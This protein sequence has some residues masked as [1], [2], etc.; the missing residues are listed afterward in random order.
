MNNQ[1]LASATFA[2]NKWHIS[3]YFLTA[4][5]NIKNKLLIQNIFFV[6]IENIIIISDELPVSITLTYEEC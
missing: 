5:I 6:M 3:F 1:S 4:Y 2:Q